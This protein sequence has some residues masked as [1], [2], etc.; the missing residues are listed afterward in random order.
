MK[1]AV[2]IFATAV[3]LSGAAASFSTTAQPTV[4]HQTVNANLP[5]PT[6]G[7]GIPGCGM[8]LVAR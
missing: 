6:C 5:V 4:S 3:V 7:P 8:G 2:R 1:T